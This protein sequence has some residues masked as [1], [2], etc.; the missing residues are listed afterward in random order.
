MKYSE[1]SIFATSASTGFENYTFLPRRLLPLPHTALW[2][3]IAFS[4]PRGQCCLSLSHVTDC[5]SSAEGWRSVPHLPMEQRTAH[6]DRKLRCE[7]RQE[8]IDGK[9]VKHMRVEKVYLF[10]TAVT[11]L[12][13]EK[14]Q[15]NS[16]LKSELAYSCCRW[17]HNKGSH[18][19]TS[20]KFVAEWKL[21][22]GN[23]GGT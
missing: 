10:F 9:T 5:C 23:M 6:P 1:S 3:V 12:R 18:K 2:E 20:F 21:R 16:Y 8:E 14:T 22:V 15:L 19:K 11:W 17:S 13:R 7:S 4:T